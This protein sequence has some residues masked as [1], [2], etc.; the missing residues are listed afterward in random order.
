MILNK[1][2]YKEHK[3][4]PYEVSDTWNCKTYSENMNEKV[5]CPHCGKVKKI[6]RLLFFVRNTYRAWVWLCR[7]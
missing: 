2:D 6:R 3:Y 5:N 1:W 7:L 4:K